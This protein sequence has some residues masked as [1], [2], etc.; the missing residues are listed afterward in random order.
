MQQVP[1][2]HGRRP[3][4]APR[5]LSATRRHQAGTS[6]GRAAD[7]GPSGESPVEGLALLT[8]LSE[9]A[10]DMHRSL[11]LDEVVRVATDRARTIIGARQAA[12]SQTLDQ[13]PGQAVIATSDAGLGSMDE[14]LPPAGWAPAARVCHTNRPLR[15]GPAELGSARDAQGRSAPGARS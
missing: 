13:D 7:P 10:R 2:G 5:R 3:I 6:A 1:A 11:S 4:A 8:A 15:L 14:L 12:T 9:A